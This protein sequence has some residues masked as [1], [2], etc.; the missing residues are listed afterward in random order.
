MDVSKGERFNLTKETGG[1]EH[2]YIGLGWNAGQDHDLDASVFGST[3]NA[4]GDPKLTSDKHFVYFRNLKTPSG[5]IVHSGDNLTGDGDGD[6][7]QIRIHLDKLDAEGVQ[8]VS[9]VVTL[10]NAVSK[11]QNFGQVSRAYVR[12]CQMDSAGNPTTELVKFLLSDDYSKFTAVQI[13]QIYKRDDGAWA[14]N[15]TGVGYENAGIGEVLAY[16][17]N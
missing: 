8:E 9:I 13:G 3:Y 6:D 16:Y 7:E 12:V 4:A 5:S 1:D 14:F 11:G 2:F 17:A 15:P 10:Y